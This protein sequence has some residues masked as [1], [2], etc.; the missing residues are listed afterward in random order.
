MVQLVGKLEPAHWKQVAAVM[1]PIR[2]DTAWGQETKAHVTGKLALP[3]DYAD[4]IG[5]V[6][7][8]VSDL[9][10]KTLGEFPG[11]V[12]TL[13]DKGK[14][15]LAEAK[16]P[17]DLAVPGAHQLVG[18]VYDKSGKELARVAP[19]MVSVGMQQGY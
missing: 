10:G 3:P 1:M 15:T 9:D 19:R 5:K 6:I 11:T 17:S 4:Q 7:F 12:Q 8:R 13:N 16:W 14:F 2:C 18:I